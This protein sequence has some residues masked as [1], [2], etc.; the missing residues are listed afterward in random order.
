[1]LE[2]RAMAKRAITGIDC[3]LYST[4]DHLDTHTNM[5][6]LGKKDGSATITANS[7]NRVGCYNTS[8]VY[9]CNDTSEDMDIPFD[10]IARQI[11]WIRDVSPEKTFH[12]CMISIL[13]IAALD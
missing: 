8:G 13:R 7:C 6:N 12:T 3:G 9:V 4:A 1:M 2:A 5:K 11:Q 10:E